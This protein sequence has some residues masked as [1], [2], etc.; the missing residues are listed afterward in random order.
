MFPERLNGEE[1]DFAQL[2]DD[3][4]TGTV[5]WWM[6][7]PENETWA[8]RLFL[9]SGKRFFPDFIVG[10]A[11]RSSRDAIALVEIKDDGVTG[12][13]QSD[14]NVEKI[15]VRHREYQQIVWVYRDGEQWVRAQ[16]AP[17]MHRIIP[18]DRFQI[19]ELVYPD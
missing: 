15:R 11:G 18:K 6:R 12:R 2:L 16:Y 13:L 14:N 4:D 1:R 5:N 3:D 10:V 9:P 8:T 17:N 19:R 7:N